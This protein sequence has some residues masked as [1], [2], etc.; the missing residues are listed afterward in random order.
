M[1]GK[2]RPHHL[3]EKRGDFRGEFPGALAALEDLEQPVR[4]R[5]FHRMG[6]PGNGADVHPE[7]LLDVAFFDPGVVQSTRTKTQSEMIKTVRE[8]LQHLQAVV[9]QKLTLPGVAAHAKKRI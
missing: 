1:Q 6:N 7:G 9:Q 5:F 8:T 3:P 2:G 4:I